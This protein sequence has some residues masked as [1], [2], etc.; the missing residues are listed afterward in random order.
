MLAEAM[1]VHGLDRRIAFTTLSSRLVGASAV[2]M[3]V[4]YGGVATL[5]SMWISNT[6]TTAMLFPIGLSI[7]GHVGLRGTASPDA[8]A[9]LRHQHD[10]G[11][12]VRRVGRRHGARRSGR[13]RT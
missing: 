6:A 1:F 11:D 4:A 3:L 9:A 8:R 13:R 5:I 2:R 12:V 10:A 7:V